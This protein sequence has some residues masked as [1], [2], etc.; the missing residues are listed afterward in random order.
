MPDTIHI[1]NCTSNKISLIYTVL[2]QS[3]RTDRSGQTVQTLIR[4]LWAVW[5]GSTLFAIPSA[6]LYSPQNRVLGGYT[7]FS[8]SVILKFRQHLR[9]LLYNF[10]SFCPI[11]FKLHHTLTIG[12][13]MFDRKIGAEG[14]VLQELCHFVI[15]IIRCCI[16]TDSTYFVKLVFAL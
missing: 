7:V 3:F 11:L 14:S 9:L 10:D 12:Q 2:I 16:I 4:L 1:V 13:C 5:S 8:M 15:L 6:S